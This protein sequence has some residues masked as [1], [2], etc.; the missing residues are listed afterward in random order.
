MSTEQTTTA[1]SLSV[2]C[3][4]TGVW[5][6]GAVG[7]WLLA[8]DPARIAAS[9][10]REGTMDEIALQVECPPTL[11]ADIQR[12]L[13]IALH[14]RVPIEAVESGTLPRFELKAKRVDDR[15]RR[16]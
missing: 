3:C 9:E 4:G 7:A 10:R 8:G 16:F 14:L 12:E 13:H 15:R 6:K 11:V 5:I 1:V 2:A